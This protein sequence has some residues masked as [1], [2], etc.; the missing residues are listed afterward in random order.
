MNKQH[1][2]EQWKTANNNLI[3]LLIQYLLYVAVLCDKYW[4]I[5]SEPQQIQKALS[6]LKE[7]AFWVDQIIGY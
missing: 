6:A 7:P 2:I 5:V 4:S 3:K 1:T